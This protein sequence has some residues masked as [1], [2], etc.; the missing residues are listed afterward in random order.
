M[1]LLLAGRLAAKWQPN[2][3]SHDWQ[4]SLFIAGMVVPRLINV[5]LLIRLLT[6]ELHGDQQFVAWLRLHKTAF[7]TLFVMSILRLDN[8][9]LLISGLFHL[10]V[11][12]AP[13]PPAICNR[14]SALGLVQNMLGDLPQLVVAWHLKHW[15]NPYGWHE[16]AALGTV[17]S[18]VFSLL[19]QLADRLLTI[20]LLRE[21]QEPVQAPCAIEDNLLFDWMLTNELMHAPSASR[22]RA[23]HDR[24]SVGATEPLL[25]PTDASNSTATDSPSNGPQAILPLVIDKC[26]NRHDG[27]GVP[28]PDSVLQML[29]DARELFR[30]L[31]RRRGRRGRLASER[32]EPEVR[33]V[34]AVI[35]AVL[36]HDGLDLQSA[37]AMR[38]AIRQGSIQDHGDDER[39]N[40]WN[41]HELA[42]SHI[43]SAL[44]F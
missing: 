14:M 29:D 5:V 11:F 22:A 25:S 30:H 21:C 33:T 2:K 32:G 16:W 4:P 13:I 35:D 1:H 24:S 36:A 34:G 12:Q 44:P 20:V 31:K 41:K 27:E 38:G 18:N 19:Y 7:A 26:N 3:P 40:E 15:T 39:V 28:V 8:F 43:A 6:V 9:S 37:S 17:V 23:D 10:K 42:A